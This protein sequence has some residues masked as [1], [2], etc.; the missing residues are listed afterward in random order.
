MVRQ[1]QKSFLLIVKSWWAIVPFHAN[2][3][4]KVPSLPSQPTPLRRPWS[5]FLILYAISFEVDMKR[6]TCFD[7]CNFQVHWYLLDQILIICTIESFQLDVKLTKTFD[8][9]QKLLKLIINL[10]LKR[11]LWRLMQFL[12]KGPSIKDITSF[13]LNFY[14]PPS[15]PCLHR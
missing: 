14:Y 8:S 10:R 12:F 4:G 7:V 3:C 1:D 13:F 2:K 6:R 9:V 5:Y 15:S 11:D